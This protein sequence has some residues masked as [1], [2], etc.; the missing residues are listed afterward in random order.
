MI[1]KLFNQKSWPFF[2]SAH[3]THT[4]SLQGQDLASSSSSIL[5]FLSSRLV[6]PDCPFKPSKNFLLPWKLLQDPL[7]IGKLAI[8]LLCCFDQGTK[9]TAWC[10]ALKHKPIVHSFVSIVCTLFINNGDRIR[11]AWQGFFTYKYLSM[12]R[13]QTF[14]FFP[15]N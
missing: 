15:F 8:T 13:L 4:F 7:L 6:R 10:I 3:S 12:R 5:L 2:L 9:N 11:Q 14:F 1:D